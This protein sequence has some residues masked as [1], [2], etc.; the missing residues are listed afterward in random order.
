MK[1]TPLTDEYYNPEVREGFRIAEMTKRY[2]ALQL[3]TLEAI[4]AVCEKHGIRWFAE[5]GT[6]LGAVRHR[7]FIP[8]DDDM[9]ITMFREDYYHFLE[10]AEKELPASYR[11]FDVTNNDGYDDPLGRIVNNGRIQFDPTYL[12]DNCGCPYTAGVDIFLLDCIYDDEEK[13]QDRCDRAMELRRAYDMV[14]GGGRDLPECR[15]L[16]RRFRSRFDVVLPLNDSL[17]HRLAELIWQTYGE[18]DPA[19]S[20]YVTYMKGWTAYRLYKRER[21]WY[22]EVIYLPFENLEIPAPA[23]YDKVLRAEYGDYMRIDR[24]G[25]VAHPYP[26]YRMQQDILTEHLASHPDER[27]SAYI[28]ATADKHM[29][30]DHKCTE[31]LDM[32]DQVTEMIRTKLAGDVASGKALLQGMISLMDGLAGLIAEDYSEEVTALK[33]IELIRRMISDGAAADRIAA[34]LTALR[35]DITELYRGHGPIETGEPVHD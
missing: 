22:D 24:G 19:E 5:F 34:Q 1:I 9:D 16:L 30:H 28:T 35:S 7:G 8:W 3:K 21:A 12:G 33:R 10:V 26:V 23:E 2:M 6:L 11:V 29:E 17:G 32:C 13:E 31:I 20:T 4:D 15:E 27:L 18:C 25:G 14:T